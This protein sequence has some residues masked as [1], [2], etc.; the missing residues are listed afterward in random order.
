ML[1]SQLCLYLPLNGLLENVQSAYR[2]GCSIETALLY[3]LNDLS[4]VFDSGNTNILWLL[5]L[6]AAF[7]TIDLTIL[8]ERLCIM[9]GFRKTARK[10][11]MP[12]LLNRNETVC[13]DNVVSVEKSVPIVSLKDRCRDLFCFILNTAHLASIIKGYGVIHHFLRMNVSYMSTQ[14]QTKVTNYEKFV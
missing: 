13:I 7:I 12:Y 5:D 9:F 6:S 8:V 2:K 1:P 11:F 3:V 10:W 14:R 4:K